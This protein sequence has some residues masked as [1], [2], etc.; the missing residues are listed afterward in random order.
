MDIQ[1]SFMNSPRK[2][3]TKYRNSRNPYTK[4]TEL[5]SELFYDVS[6]LPLQW[7]Q[8]TKTVHTARFGLESFF[9]VFLGCII[10]L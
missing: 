9:N 10:Y 7:S 6:V 1:A 4:P 2:K 5:F 3:L 8:L